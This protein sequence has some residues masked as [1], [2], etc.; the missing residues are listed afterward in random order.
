MLTQQQYE[1]IICDT[2]T[3]PPGPSADKVSPT[4]WLIVLKQ[5]PN[6]PRDRPMKNVRD[7]YLSSKPLKF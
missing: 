2:S 3:P 5:L 6:C 7:L 4:F 1:F